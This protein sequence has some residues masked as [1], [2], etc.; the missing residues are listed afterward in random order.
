MHQHYNIYVY[1][2][3]SH[4]TATPLSQEPQSSKQ[5]NLT[6]GK[7]VCKELTEIAYS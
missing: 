2:N 5:L 4:I 3:S 1:Y 7:Q 6:A